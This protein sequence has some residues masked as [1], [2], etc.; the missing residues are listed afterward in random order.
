VDYNALINQGLTPL[1]VGLDV[2]NRHT[3]SHTIN[4]PDS[5]QGTET[6]FSAKRRKDLRADKTGGASN[7]NIHSDKNLF[8][9]ASGK[10][11]F[12]T[13]RWIKQRSFFSDQ[14]EQELCK[15]NAA[16]AA[17]E[18]TSGKARNRLACGA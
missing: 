12:Y 3:L 5:R 9:F 7:E 6:L 2:S 17:E 8:K 1:R 15:P 10:E 11:M 13:Q 4:L 18:A 14:T 16:T